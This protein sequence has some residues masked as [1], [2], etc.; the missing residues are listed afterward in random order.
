MKRIRRVLQVGLA[1]FAL[2]QPVTSLG[3]P[4]CVDPDGGIGGTG[5]TARSGGIGGTG[6]REDGQGGIGGTGAPQRETGGTGGVGGTG[7]RAGDGAR[8]NGDGQGGIGGTGVVADGTGGTG[9]PSDATRVGVFG[10]ITG[11]AS[12]CVNG[13]EVHYQPQTP[14]T[15]NGLPASTAALAVGQVIA[16]E[17]VKGPGGWNARA[18][19]IVNALEGP[20]TALPGPDGRFLVMGHPVKLARGAKMAVGSLRLG[21]PVKVSGLPGTGGVVFATRV[22]GAPS[23]A[24]ASVAGLVVGAK[25][26]GK[27]GAVALAGTATP[28]QA[29]VRGQWNGAQLVVTKV[30]PDP[31]TKVTGTGG[32]VVLEALVT[33]APV[34]GKIGAGGRVIDL[35]QVGVAAAAGASALAIEQRIVVTGRIDAAGTV[36]AVRIDPILRP[37]EATTGAA[38]AP[39]SMG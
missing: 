9:L 21:M 22:Q 38:P 19:A 25:G 18:L 26:A 28:G 27:V 10:T 12:V 11:F 32:L 33:G 24:G 29:V 6:S 8:S 15:E 37:G 36:R 13:L 39:A 30:L 4:V 31:V 7:S 16:I 35:G 34:A 23:A 17:A 20:V 2:G 5:V 3:G 1:L 14:V